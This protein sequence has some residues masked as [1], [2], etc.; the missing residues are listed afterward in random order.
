MAWRY[1]KH[2]FQDGDII[3]PRQWNEN[4]QQF[5]DEFNGYLDKDNLPRGAIDAQMIT[6]NA[7]S[8]TY[9]VSHDGIDNSDTQKVTYVAPVES[10]MW[11]AV[12][13]NGTELC[14][15]SIDVET[16][17][18]AIV[19]FTC[20]WSWR[21]TAAEDSGTTPGGE[22][23]SWGGGINYKDAAKYDADHYLSSGTPDTAKLKMG[24]DLPKRALAV[25]VTVDGV[26]IS[27]TGRLHA[28]NCEDGIYLVGA[29]PLQPGTHVFQAE[30]RLV[31][32][33]SS[34]QDE[35]TADVAFPRW[36]TETTMK[37]T[38]DERSG[39]VA[40]KTRAM[41]IQLRSR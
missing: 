8:R 16:D 33:E 26:P 12:D 6:D 30:E 37:E 21:H 2:H 34:E 19:E 18:V 29:T 40:F 32:L 14:K 39:N 36:D 11:T 22:T 27:E 35:D 5:T 15:K 25:R 23:F 24:G 41:V 1:Q 20:H 9:L 31:Y 28:G 38:V 4:I 10:T 13:N 17:C 7:F 3:H